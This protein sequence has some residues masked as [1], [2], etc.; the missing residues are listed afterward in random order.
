MS[1][2]AAPANGDRRSQTSRNE[3]SR[4]DSSRSCASSSIIHVSSSIGSC[5]RRQ[6]RTWPAPTAPVRTHSVISSASARAL[7]GSTECGS[8]GSGATN[9]RAHASVTVGRPLRRAPSWVL[10]RTSRSRTIAST[11]WA[12]RAAASR[13]PAGD[14][15]VTNVATS[16]R[17]DAPGNGHHHE[18]ARPSSSTVRPGMT[19]PLVTSA[20][21]TSSTAS[22]LG[23]SVRAFSRDVATARPSCRAHHAAA[24]H[25]TTS[26]RRR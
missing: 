7:S 4:L 18:R 6:S 5:T 2:I 17:C 9:A 15:S 16:D 13:C 10:A 8:H 3:T 19:C 20:R 22:S 25:E 23:P 21:A 11:A 1:S 26:W 14:G 12:S 24:P